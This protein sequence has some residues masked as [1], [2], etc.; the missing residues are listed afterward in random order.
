MSAEAKCN[1]QH[2]SGHILF[3][4]EMAGQM[5]VCP[6]CGLE[7]KLYVPAIPQDVRVEIK[8]GVSPLG[9]ASLVLG[10]GAS[11]FCWIPFLGL[12]AIPISA[13]GFLLATIGITAAIVGKKSGLS[14]PIGG[15]VICVVATLIALFVT[16]GISSLIAKHEV[17]SNSTNQKIPAESSLDSPATSAHR[18][19][20]ADEPTAST[21]TDLPAATTPQAESSSVGVSWSKSF[22]VQQDDVQVSVQSVFIFPT[23]VHNLTGDV[24]PSRNL[25]LNIKMLVSNLSTG[26]KIDFTTWRGENF[27]TKNDS[28]TLT[29]NNGNTY[30]KI[31][32]DSGLL[33][34]RLDEAQDNISIYPTNSFEDLLVF[35]LPVANLKW[36]HLE[37]SAENFGGSGMLRFEIPPSSIQNFRLIGGQK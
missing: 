21:P 6:L 25:Y 18:P 10:I 17:Q 5:T 31:N 11:V 9:I 4:T 1:C 30:K 2:C 8:R 14:F 12:L 29:D 33:N 13:I 37:L 27:S 24:T 22:T 26:K 34:S 19:P 16:G 23:Y 35:E 32:F 7:T 28:A 36:L 15:A 20:S 3:P